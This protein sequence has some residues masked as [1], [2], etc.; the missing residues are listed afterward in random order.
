MKTNKRMQ[1]LFLLGLVLLC[2]FI[3][4][5]TPEQGTEPS[6]TI[7]EA[8]SYTLEQLLAMQGCDLSELKC[9]A[10]IPNIHSF[11]QHDYEGESE[12][13]TQIEKINQ[14]YALITESDYEELRDENL[15]HLYLIFEDQE[16]GLFFTK[17]RRVIMLCNGAY[18]ISEK[19]A[20]FEDV[21]TPFYYDRVIVGLTPGFGGVNKEINLADFAAANIILESDITDETDLTGKIIIT[22]VVDTT[23]T[24]KPELRNPDTFVQVLCFYL[25]ESSRDTVLELVNRMEQ[26]D[27][28]KYAQPKYIYYAADANVGIATYSADNYWGDQWGL[29]ANGINISEAWNMVGNGKTTPTKRDVLN[30]ENQKPNR[31]N[32][33]TVW[34][35]GYAV[36]CF[37]KI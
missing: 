18:Y 14:K 30:G 13:T 21:T 9:M 12:L 24:E 17:D 23:H 22:S 3:S 29:S 31:I 20:V 4:G 33:M 37:L 2:F 19:E 32:K 6:E 7:K 15:A 26:I 8:Y 16:A 10:Y 5:C 34:S 1:A 25:K 35:K 28:V 36:F 11:R 27:G